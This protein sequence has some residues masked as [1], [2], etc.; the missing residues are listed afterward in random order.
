V[1]RQAGGIDRE[2][3]ERV[4]EAVAGCQPA[5]SLLVLTLVSLPPSRS[6]PATLS[7]SLARQICLAFLPARL[8]VCTSLDVSLISRWLRT[9]WYRAWRPGI[10]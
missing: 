6:F 1:Y 3:S 10:A 8:Y 5:S 4:R 2:A 7:A 9:R